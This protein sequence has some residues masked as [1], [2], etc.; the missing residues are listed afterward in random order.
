MKYK[1]I[2]SIV[3]AM[4]FAFGCVTKTKCPPAAYW[5]ASRSV[6]VQCPGSE[7]VDLGKAVRLAI[8]CVQADPKR[9]DKVFADLINIAQNNPN[10]DN[11]EKIYEFIRKVAIDSPYVATRKA[12]M[13]WNRYFSPYMFVTIGY[14]F[15][16]ISNKCSSKAEI[17][18]QIED[19][20]N[21]KKIGILYCMGDQANKGDVQTY[22]RQAEE[23]A[24][25][26]KVSLDAI[27]LACCKK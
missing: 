26:L 14:D 18:R 19:E 8:G 17:K 7:M 24:D 1:A 2:V 25:S 3:F 9:F 21:D 12:K 23:T 13:K 15:E 6:C 11:G 16:K 20:L 10:I 22:Y 27:C 5:D 4:L